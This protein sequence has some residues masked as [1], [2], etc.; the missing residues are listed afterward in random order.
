MSAVVALEVLWWESMLG[1]GIVGVP[2]WWL[3][4]GI[5]VV[6]GFDWVDA[7]RVWV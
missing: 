2:V 3:H 4:L 1:F 6:L 5:V 7:L